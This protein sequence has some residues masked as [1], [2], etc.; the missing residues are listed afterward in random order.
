MVLCS[1]RP[2]DSI[3]DVSISSPPFSLLLIQVCRGVQEVEPSRVSVFHSGRAGTLRV[4]ALPHFRNTSLKFFFSLIPAFFSTRFPFSN[5]L[6]SGIMEASRSMRIVRLGRFPII[7]RVNGLEFI[8]FLS[9]TKNGYY[10]S[11]FDKFLASSR[12]IQCFGV[13]LLSVFVCLLFGVKES[14][15]FGCRR[16]QSGEI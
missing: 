11:N 4:I 15:C 16:M 1:W 5:C 12:R 6:L 14:L 3:G 13:Y 2:T 8:N 7:C 10:N 9:V